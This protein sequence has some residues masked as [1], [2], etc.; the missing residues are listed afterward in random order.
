M[1]YLPVII[2]LLCAIVFAITVYDLLHGV[3][4][5]VTAALTAAQQSAADAGK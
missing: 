4:E 2:A 5:K 1:K 3:A